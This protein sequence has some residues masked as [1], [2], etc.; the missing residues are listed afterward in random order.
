[1]NYADYENDYW[2][3]YLLAIAKMREL[4]ET[5]IAVC[6]DPPQGAV[7]VSPSAG[8]AHGDA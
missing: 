8:A 3:S 1:M 5:E 6:V 4:N 7:P 2:G